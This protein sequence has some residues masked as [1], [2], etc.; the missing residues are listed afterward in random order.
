[1]SVGVRL[2]NVSC[3]VDGCLQQRRVVAQLR[4]RQAVELYGKG[5]M[6]WIACDDERIVTSLWLGWHLTGCP[7]TKGSS[8]SPSTSST[9]SLHSFVH[10]CNVMLSGAQ[11][12]PHIDCNGIRGKVLAHLGSASDT[13]LRISFSGCGGTDALGWALSVCCFWVSS[14]PSLLMTHACTMIMIARETSTPCVRTA[15]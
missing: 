8:E 6:F 5:V 1:M 4:R 12:A 9:I 11:H 14:C 7:G 13:W 15:L 2:V 3:P 10:S